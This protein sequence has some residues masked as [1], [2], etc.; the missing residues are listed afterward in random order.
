MRKNKHFADFIFLAITNSIKITQ[1]EYQ[2]RGW[3]SLRD[4]SLTVFFTCFGNF[5]HFCLDFHWFC[6]P[7]TGFFKIFAIFHDFKPMILHYYLADFEKFTHKT[8]LRVEINR[9]R[10]VSQR[11]VKNKKYFQHVTFHSISSSGGSRICT[12]PPYVFAI[13]ILPTRSSQFPCTKI[14]CWWS[15]Q[16]HDK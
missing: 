8:Y 7:S 15:V 3:C 11:L 6:V 5:E 13:L 2:L 1:S 10:M 14:R 9:L 16:S 4:L 12:T